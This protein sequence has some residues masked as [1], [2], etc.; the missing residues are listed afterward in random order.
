MV[1]DDGWRKF[2]THSFSP[3]T[4]PQ[5]VWGFEP[6]IFWLQ[7]AFL[8][9]PLL[10]LPLFQSAVRFFE[11]IC[12][13]ASSRTCSTQTILFLPCRSHSAGLLS[14]HVVTAFGSHSLNG[15]Q[16]L[17]VSLSAWSALHTEITTLQSMNTELVQS[18]LF[19][20]YWSRGGCSNIFEKSATASRTET[21]HRL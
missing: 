10:V 7:R 14:K 15:C 20:N 21:I 13:H 17:E 9:Q 2:V 12:R 1:A 8:L 19:L 4:F 16:L 11:C 3:P 5:M 18:C 6:M